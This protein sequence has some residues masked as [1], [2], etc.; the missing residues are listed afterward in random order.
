MLN[1][2]FLRLYAFNLGRRFRSTPSQACADALLQMVFLL[3]LPLW[4]ALGLLA[5]WLQA[6][7]S[8]V[9]IENLAFILF[10]VLLLPPLILWLL[11]K[12]NHYRNIPDAASPFR[13]RRERCKSAVIIALPLLIAVVLEL[14][15]RELHFGV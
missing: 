10:A 7:E 14:V 5:S 8:A 6:H 15:N 1:L 12:F 13:S 4:M 11:R 9:H 2:A 3:V